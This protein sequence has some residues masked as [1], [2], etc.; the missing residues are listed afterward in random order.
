MAKRPLMQVP[1]AVKGKPP[2]AIR[3]LAPKAKT[4]APKRGK[5]A[6]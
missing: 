2:R 6:Y 4:G 1:A 3:P 5:M